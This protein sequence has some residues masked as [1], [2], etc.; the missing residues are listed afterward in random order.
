MCN[1]DTNRVKKKGCINMAIMTKPNN[2][3]F[4]VD[5][6]KTNVFLHLS[7]SKS[8]EKQMKKSANQIAKQIKRSK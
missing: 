7:V 1:K 6:K 4:R 8:H 3:A 5:E 2:L